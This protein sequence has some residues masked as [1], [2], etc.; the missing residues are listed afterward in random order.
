M[1]S[2]A[3]IL[4]A[5]FAGRIPATSP[6]SVANTSAASMSQGGMIEMAAL[7]PPL[8]AAP[9][10]YQAF[11]A[12]FSVAVEVNGPSTAD[13][14]RTA[15][16]YLYRVGSGARCAS[17]IRGSG[18]TDEEERGGP[19]RDEAKSRASS[20]SLRTLAAASSE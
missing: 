8:P 5:L 19:E 17:H 12:P 6:T 15:S 11:R 9:A 16:L 2:S 7:P 1:A 4:T 18:T 13:F 3:L 10:A 14:P 20:N